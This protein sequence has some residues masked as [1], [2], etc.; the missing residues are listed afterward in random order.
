MPLVPDTELVDWVVLVWSF[1]VMGQTNRADAAGHCSQMLNRA[2]RR[3]T[4]FTKDQDH[5]AFE[6]ILT[7]DIERF[8]AE[9]SSD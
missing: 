7:L 8:D 3:V 5:E 4:I 9:L 6:W 2:N 1:G